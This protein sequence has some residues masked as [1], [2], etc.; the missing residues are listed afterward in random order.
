MNKTLNIAHRG[1]SGYFPENTILAFQK[2][3]ELGCDGIETDVQL[4][5]DNIPVIIHDEFVDRTTDGKGLV[6]DYTLCELRKLDAGINFNKKYEGLKIPTLDEFLSLAKENNIMINIEIKNGVIQYKDIEKIIIE[7]LYEYKMEGRTILSSFDHYCIRRCKEIDKNIKVGLL[8][9]C[10]MYMPEKYAK[11]LGADA[12]HPLFYNALHEEVVKGIK[13]EGIL[14]N[15]FTV[16]DEK[17]MLALLKMGV[18][19]IITNY[20]DKLKRVKESFYGTKI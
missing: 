5:K 20:P 13:K 8:Y 16:D 12:L 6:K 9:M 3:V 15:P 1:A 19:G 2:A 7:K 11:F 10:G 18:D 14:L 17:Y 4:T